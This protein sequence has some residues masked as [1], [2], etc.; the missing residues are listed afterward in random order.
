[1]FVQLLEGNAWCHSMYELSHSCPD[2]HCR[3]ELGLCRQKSWQEE[4]ALNQQL[5]TIQQ[6]VCHHGVYMDVK[7]QAP[8]LMSG[9][10]CVLPVQLPRN[11]AAAKANTTAADWSLFR[12][13]LHMKSADLQQ[14][15]C[16]TQPL[17]QM[18]WCNAV[19]DCTAPIQRPFSLSGHST[20]QPM[21]F[22]AS[23]ASYDDLDAEPK[24]D[25]R[26]MISEKLPLAMITLAATLFLLLCI[27]DSSR[28]GCPCPRVHESVVADEDHAVQSRQGLIADHDYM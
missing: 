26:S 16:Q 11:L 22:P 13:V 7:C 9:A 14:R 20:T 8:C 25:I 5:Q 15:L 23:G 21:L 10:H 17:H 4:S 12:R 3:L 27:R 18:E 28:R 6:H 19:R 24:V 2:V 1:M